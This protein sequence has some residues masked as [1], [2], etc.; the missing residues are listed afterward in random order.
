MFKV[1]HVE[2]VLFSLRGHI[3]LFWFCPL[4]VKKLPRLELPPKREGTH[5]RKKSSF[6]EVTRALTWM[7]CREIPCPTNGRHPKIPTPTKLTSSPSSHVSRRTLAAPCPRF[8]KMATTRSPAPCTSRDRRSPSHWS[9][10]G[11]GQCSLR[12]GCVVCDDK[13]QQNERLF[14]INVLFELKI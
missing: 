5:S 11:R 8:R 2:I 14:M 10:R 6:S 7:G 1:A 4:D 3:V 12:T 13:M 9:C